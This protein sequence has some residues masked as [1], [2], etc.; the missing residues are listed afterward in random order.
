[1]HDG[2]LAPGA[3]VVERAL[4][5][6]REFCG[7][8][9]AYVSEFQDGSQW[10]RRYV[11]DASRFAV[12]LDEPIPLEATYCMRMVDGRLPG[13]VPDVVADARIGGLPI[14]RDSGTGAYVG[15]PIRLPDGELYGTLCCIDPSARPQLSERHRELVQ[16]LAGVIGEQIGRTERDRTV[17]RAQNEFLAAVSHDL[18]T[19]L[20][21]I[22][23]IAEDLADG[24]GRRTPEEAGRVIAGEVRTLT[25]MVDDVLLV[26][27]QRSGSA[28]LRRADVELTELARDAVRSSTLAAGVAEGR[29][30]LDLPDGALHAE[31]DGPRVAQA[32]RNLLDN[33]LKFSPRDSTVL[34]RLRRDDTTAVLDVEDRGVGVTPEEADR[35]VERFYRGAGARQL[36]VDGLGLGLATVQ[37]IAEAHEGVLSV[38][39]EPGEGAAFRL[40]LPLAPPG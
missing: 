33:A 30:R 20:R 5:L 16:L 19:P 11:G 29:V 13:V 12:S 1:M 4:R 7:L 22:G 14:T 34:L 25:S 15:A 32:L 9:L 28:V 23:F 37:A 24:H 21:A 39:S 17:E 18:R 26:S 6:A 27:R 40:R 2:D 38:S 3:D 8:E 31:V 10:I 35:L 36:G